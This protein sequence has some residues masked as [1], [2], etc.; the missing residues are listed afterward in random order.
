MILKELIEGIDN[1]ELEVFNTEQAA[2]AW[3]NHN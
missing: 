3:L 1:I 2:L